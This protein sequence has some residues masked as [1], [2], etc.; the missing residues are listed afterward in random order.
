[1]KDQNKDHEDEIDTCWFCGIS[2]GPEV[3]LE[4]C[5]FCNLVSYC[6]PRH[7]KLHRPKNYCY[8]IRVARHP[9]KGIFL[10]ILF[11][12]MIEKKFDSND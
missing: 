2:S 4:K 9:T 5:E 1:M 11:N 10:Q 6:G 7:Q 12:H 8:P 3:Q